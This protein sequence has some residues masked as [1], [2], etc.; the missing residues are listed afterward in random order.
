MEGFGFVVVGRTVV[1]LT[2]GGFTV[3]LPVGCDVRYDG[4]KVVGF[5]VILLVGFGE[6]TTTI[7]DLVGLCVGGFGTAVEGFGFAVVG[8]TVVGLTVNVGGFTVAVPVGCDVRYDGLKVIG[9][10]VILLVG[11]GEGTA[12]IAD[13]VGL[14]VGGFGFAVMS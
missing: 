8:R 11:F 12:I 6:G 10:N 1:G 14:C 5:N 2:V 9:F 4:L 7:A 3:V 13:L